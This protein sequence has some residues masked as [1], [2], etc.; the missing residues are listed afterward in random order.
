MNHNQNPLSNFKSQEE[1][2]NFVQRE[3]H[4]MSQFLFENQIIAYTR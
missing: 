1:L 2:E 4:E 3:F